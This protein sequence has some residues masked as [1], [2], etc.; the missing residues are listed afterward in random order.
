M[1]Q[2]SPPVSLP[3]IEVTETESEI[4]YCWAYRLA[5]AMQ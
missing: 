5:N 2:I 3:Q 4:W 1:A